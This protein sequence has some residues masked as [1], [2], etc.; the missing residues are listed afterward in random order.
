MLHWSG[1]DLWLRRSG[2]GLGL[3]LCLSRNGLGLGCLDCLGLCCSFVA[4]LGL[5]WVRVGVGWS[6]ILLNVAGFL[7]FQGYGIRLLYRIPR[8][9]HDRASLRERV[10]MLH[11]SLKRRIPGLAPEGRCTSLCGLPHVV[12]CP[13][14]VAAP[15]L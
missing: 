4:G 2:V 3:C 6:W 12:N 9:K 11:L 7:E 15:F 10:L 1:V 8:Q 13:A 14:V 5:R